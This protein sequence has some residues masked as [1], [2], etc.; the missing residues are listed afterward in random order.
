MNS[1]L[2]KNIIYLI[3][4]LLVINLASAITL[5]ELIASY[6]FNYNDDV[7]NITS[8]TH[9]GVDIN[10]N[11]LYDY[12]IIE[13][14]TDNLEASY[15]VIGDL[16]LDNNL[17]TTTHNETYLLYGENI[18]NLVYNPKLLTDGT[19]NLSLVINE[20]YFTHY[21]DLN[22]Y[23]FYFDSSEYEQPD[24]DVAIDSHNF[25]D[26]D[27]DPEYEALQIT[28]DINVARD[29]TYLIKAYIKDDNNMVYS[30]E[31]YSLNS[32]FNEVDIEFASK[33][34]R[35]KRL[36]YSELYKIIV[37][38]NETPYEFSFNY[39]INYDL[40]DFD[41]EQSI[42]TGHF[43]D[44]KID[45]DA[46]NLSDYIELEI[47]VWALA[48]EYDLELILYDGNDE[49]YDKIYETYYLNNGNNL[50]QIEINGT[51]IY[52]NKADGPFRISS[53]K[54]IQDNET[55]DTLINPYITNMFYF[56]DFEQPLM[57]D[58]TF[59]GFS[60]ENNQI[61]SKIKNIG[62]VHSYGITVNYFDQNFTQLYEKT[63]IDLA[64]NQE[65]EINFDY[66]T[67]NV[68]QIFAFIDYNNEIEET[69]ESNNLFLLEIGKGIINIYLIQGWNLISVPLLL[70]NNTIP[71]PFETI[72]GNYTTIYAY[73]A[74]TKTWDLYDPTVPDFLNTLSIIDITMG[75]WIK[76]LHNDTLTIEGTI[77]DSIYFTIYD[78]WNLIGYPYL[79]TQDISFVFENVN[80]TFSSI[81]QYNALD[82]S[83]PWKLYDLYV[84][85]FL[86]DLYS[87]TPGFGYWVKALENTT[88]TFNGSFY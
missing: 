53:I 30:I 28:T 58:L 14:T 10:S 38:D 4:L 8:I 22:S 67:T 55:I 3:L 20:D 68:T 85:E 32:G 49:F 2:K 72:E 75:F 59:T 45:L 17:K 41:P 80:D 27:S 71:K 12:L 26:N 9:Y 11:A 54:L 86:T 34:I 25:I 33:D 24:I 52:M 7:I 82:I 83:D 77:P 87:I 16:L 88:W 51:E 44:T 19:Y 50:L 18:V 76:M 1:S 15:D 36:N 40:N 23:S 74:E 39:I 31:N 57:P 60:S 84:P 35:T 56:S 63:I 70:E 64:V 21:R 69:N 61:Y 73:D 6:D 37:V 42:F 66:N 43:N 62:A 47:G 48:G 13:L 65:Q 5:E 29:N 79:T 78:D 81:Y 46:N